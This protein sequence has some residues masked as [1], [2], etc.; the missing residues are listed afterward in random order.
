MHPQQLSGFATPSGFN[1]HLVVQGENNSIAHAQLAFG[2][3]IVMLGSANRPDS[4]YGKLV[5]APDPSGALTQTV[6]VVVPDADAIY[7]RA[8]RAEAE[9]LISIKNEE[10][11]GRGF[12]CRDP[13]RHI[14]NFG[15]YD[16]FA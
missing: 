1:K 4:E 6:Y 3:G 10:Y 2:N 14:W 12:T 9:I 16:P 11:G 13:E 15:T 5:K 8:R 7:E